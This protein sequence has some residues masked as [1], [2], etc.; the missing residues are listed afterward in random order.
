[1]TTTMMTVARG[2]LIGLTALAPAAALDAWTQACDADG[3][4]CLGQVLIALVTGPL[5]A[6]VAGWIAARLLGQPR[7]ILLAFAGP[8]AA[9]ALLEATAEVAARA[10]WWLGWPLA[11]AALTLLVRAIGRDDGDEHL[12]RAWQQLRHLARRLP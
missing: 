2:V 1:M 11:Y 10:P 12:P 9:W 8:L 5:L 4:G 3:F 7:P 6:V